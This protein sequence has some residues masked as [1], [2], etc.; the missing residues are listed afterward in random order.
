MGNG[1]GIKY[2][3][4][5]LLGSGASPRGVGL[6]NT[7]QMFGGGSS[8]VGSSVGGLNMFGA[9]SIETPDF[10]ATKFVSE[11]Q[12]AVDR[13]A[14]IGQNIKAGAAMLASE[15]PFSGMLGEASG[16]RAQDRLADEQFQYDVVQDKYYKTDAEGNPIASPQAGKYS[17]LTE[18]LY[19]TI[20]KSDFELDNAPGGK[21]RA[22]NVLGKMAG[23]A[24]S[25]AAMGAQVGGGWGALIGGVIGLAGG[26]ISGGVSNRRN[27]EEAEARK[28]RMNDLYIDK[29]E[30]QRQKRLNASRQLNQVGQEI[31]SANTEA[32]KLALNQSVNQAAVQNRG[33]VLGLANTGVNKAGI[34]D[35]NQ[36]KQYKL[37]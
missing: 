12:G 30:E 6:Q 3:P 31:V 21:E 1:T 24:A 37:A 29:L 25:G 22:G 27:K 26:A 9:R 8:G 34:M 4:T 17:F 11:G 32:D 5:S 19:S 36:D 13:N 28:K 16:R 20:D 18:D 10:N 14:G 33:N 15:E 23:G 7:G 35:I 2:D